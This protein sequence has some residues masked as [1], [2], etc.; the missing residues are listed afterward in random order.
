[1]LRRSLQTTSTSTKGTPIR[2]PTARQSSRVEGPRIH[3]VGDNGLA[4]AQVVA[5]HGMRNGVSLTLHDCSAVPER[6][7]D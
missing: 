7:F 6:L 4:N 5:S 2:S 1:M 3:A